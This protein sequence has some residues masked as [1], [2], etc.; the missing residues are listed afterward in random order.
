MC[1]LLLIFG[2]SCNRILSNYFSHRSFFFYLRHRLSIKR[3]L[4]K[5]TLNRFPV[6]KLLYKKKKKEKHTQ[7]CPFSRWLLANGKHEKVES[8]YQRMAR[9]NGL[10]ISEEAIGA[11]KELNMVKTEKVGLIFKGVQRKTFEFETISGIVFF[12]RNNWY[13]PKRSHQRCKF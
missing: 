3:V 5:D 7:W 12:R 4:Y 9:I 6:R 8:I 10:Q 11:F 2:S 1:R 13:K